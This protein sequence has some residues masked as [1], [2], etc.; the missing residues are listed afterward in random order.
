MP[1]H[2]PEEILQIARDLMKEAGLDA[3]NHEFLGMGLLWRVYFE[4]KAGEIGNHFTIVINDQTLESRFVG[5]R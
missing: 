3:E 4:G 1:L 2:T 5:G